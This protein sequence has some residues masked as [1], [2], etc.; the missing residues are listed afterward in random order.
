MATMG[1]GGRSAILG[2]GDGRPA[3][4]VE[5]ALDGPEQAAAR[6][7]ARR[8]DAARALQDAVDRVAA[9]APGGDALPVAGIHAALTLS[10]VRFAERHG[11]FGDDYHPYHNENHALEVL[12]GRLLRLA[13]TA[14]QSGR[15]LSGRQFAA[16]SLFATGHDLHQRQRVDYAKAVGD[17]ETA[18]LH[19]MF[20]ILER[21]GLDPDQQRWLFVALELMI[22]GSTFDPRP[23]PDPDDYSPAVALATGGALAP[24]LDQLLDE[25]QPGWR[26]DDDIVKGLE[27]AALAADLDTANVGE[28][29]VWLAE[30]A[31]RL[32]REREWRE[33]RSLSSAE[34]V[35]T[36]AG[37]LSSGQE[38]YFFD[39]HRFCS[40]LGEACFGPGKVQNAA[41]VRQLSEALQNDL[42]TRPATDGNDVLDR[43]ARLALTGGET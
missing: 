31:C 37:F 12:Q 20:R 14:A 42:A 10:F 19:E 26:D 21:C 9:A 24:R 22:A 32:C 16:L 15:A 43:F 8:P 18:S 1:P 11:G 6:L 23:H 3:D 34:S 30:S 17:N 4:L 40:A 28:D 41:R 39:L 13:L 2:T 29:F 38:R 5:A 7:Q 25:R 35:K 27:L 36:C 33:G